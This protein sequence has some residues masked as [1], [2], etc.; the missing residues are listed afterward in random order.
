MRK[1]AKDTSSEGIEYDRFKI[2]PPGVKRE[3]EE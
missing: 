3:G 1:T 2:K